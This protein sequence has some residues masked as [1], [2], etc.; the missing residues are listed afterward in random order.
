MCTRNNTINQSRD[1]TGHSRSRSC[2]QAKRFLGVQYFRPGT[3]YNT[4]VFMNSCYKFTISFQC[5]ISRP[6]VHLGMK[7]FQ[8]WKVR[9]FLQCTEICLRSWLE[10][11]EAHYHPR[12]SYH[13]STHAADVL[14][15][16]AFY[17][18]KEKVAVKEGHLNY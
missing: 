9:E 3:T 14:Q 10:V 4:K 15:A 2:S 11:I 16:A 17:L 7:I 18:G 6:L 5:R 1:Q 12:N 8:L 13:N